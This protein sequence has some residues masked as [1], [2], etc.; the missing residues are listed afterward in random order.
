MYILDIPVATLP[1]IAT[2]LAIPE[3]RLEKCPSR[4]T[5]ITIYNDSKATTPASTLAAVNQLQQKHKGPIR[6]ILG[7][8][9]KGVDRAPFIQQ[10]KNKVA[11]VYC[12]GAEG[13]QLAFWCAQQQIPVEN[14]ARLEE[15]VALSLDQAAPGDQLLF[16]P[17]GNSYDLF[18]DYAH[19][20]TVFKKLVAEHRGK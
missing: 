1:E 18:K 20:G 13:E 17:A 7:G 10:L 11:K 8:L 6:L 15:I 2:K 3:H 9:S 14:C 12:F 16:S 4:S 5:N 19:R